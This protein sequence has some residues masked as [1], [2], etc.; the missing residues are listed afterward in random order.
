MADIDVFELLNQLEN[1]VENTKRYVYYNIAD[2]KVLHIRNYKEDDQSP[3]IEV[4]TKD[5]NESKSLS[6]YLVVP[7]NNK[8]V[9]IEV[10]VDWPDFDINN[11]IYEI[12]KTSYKP[13]EY[14]LL[15]TQNNKKKSFVVSL[16]AELKFKLRG[17]AGQ[18]RTMILYVTS[19]N[20]PNILY[21]TITISS[22]DLIKEKTLRY[23]FD[24]DYDGSI[25]CN[26][27]TR[28]MF[29]N[30]KHWEM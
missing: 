14:D 2:G 11:D 23:K 24:N 20:D 13:K 9:L 5:I 28:K 19:E 6:D 12:E 22:D 10:K 8:M 3:F 17:F 16:S 26:I 1:P 4:D 25:P 15:I 27:Y 7:H 30:Y 18:T 21:S 29:E